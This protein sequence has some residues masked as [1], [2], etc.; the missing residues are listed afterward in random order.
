[1]PLSTLTAQQVA[2][3]LVL[4]PARDGLGTAAAVADV[5][6]ATVFALILAALVMLL[7]QLR[8]IHRT[9]RETTVRLEKRLD[10]MLD[11]GR[12]IAANVE[13]VSGALRTDVQR[14]SD[15]VKSLSDRLQAASDRMERRVEEFNALME[16]VQGEAEDLFLGSAAAVRGVRAGARTLRDGAPGDGS[17]L[18]P[19]PV[20]PGDPPLAGADA[21]A[22]A[23]EARRAPMR[24]P[25]AAPVAP[26]SG[27]TTPRRSGAS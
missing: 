3:T 13:F 2:D 5:A 14:V 24:P 6:L 15:T 10:P 18:D 4:L 7:F 22:A 27:E 11:R 25:G 20:S 12:D 16:V 26:L 1:M 23:L 17:E 9:V 19:L 21:E 8:G